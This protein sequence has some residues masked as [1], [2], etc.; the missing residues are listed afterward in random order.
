MR[1][2]GSLP[3]VIAL[4][5][6]IDHSNRETVKGIEDQ[7]CLDYWPGVIYGMGELYLNSIYLRGD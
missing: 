6:A 3:L 1:S 7:L 5:Q 4:R 2:I